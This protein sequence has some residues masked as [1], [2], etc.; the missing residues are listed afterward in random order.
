MLAS[1]QVRL[2]TGISS[3]DDD[4]IWEILSAYCLPWNSE[5]V[6]QQIILRASAD[7]LTRLAIQRSAE[8]RVKVAEDIELDLP[9]PKVMMTLAQNLRTQADELDLDSQSRI[10]IAE[11]SVGGML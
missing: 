4:L 7:L 10:A 5:N 8:S 9:D 2:V 11:F 3:V 6:S 1:E